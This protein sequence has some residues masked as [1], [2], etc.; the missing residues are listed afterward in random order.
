ME[1]RV[2]LVTGASLGIGKATAYRFAQAGWSL[3][4]T[5]YK[6][7]ALGLEAAEKCIKDGSPSTYALELDLTDDKSIQALKQ[8]VSEKFSSISVLVNNAG[9]FVSKPLIK[10]TFEEIRLQMRTN[11]EGPIKLTEELLPSITDSIINVSSG[12]GKTGRSHLSVYAATKFGL[13]G[14][15][16]SLAQENPRLK[17]FSVNPG[18]TA[19]R[20]NNFT[21]DPPEKVADIIYKAAIGEFPTQNGGDIDVWAV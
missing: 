20:M 18:T 6:D 8:K 12:V 13:R 5:Y 11:L 14:F 17:I 21:G 1:S 4:L 16:Q 10:Q 2:A 3:I 7:K 19:T 9:I 15:T